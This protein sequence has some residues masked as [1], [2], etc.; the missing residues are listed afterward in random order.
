MINKKKV[1][2]YVMAGA[3]GLNML[4]ASSTFAAEKETHSSTGVEASVSH[5]KTTVSIELKKLQTEAKKLNIKVDGKKADVLKKEI[6]EGQN[7]HKQAK[8]LGLEPDGKTPDTLKKE[9]EECQNL[10]KQA[11]KLGL[12]PDGKTPDTLKKEIEEGQNLH[13]QAKKLGLKVDGKTLSTLKIEI[14][15][16]LKL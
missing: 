8:K 14:Q 12:E 15:Q 3:L 1:F 11:K 16:H 9:I 4:G 2:G 6:E 13:K 7:L 10:H 5:D